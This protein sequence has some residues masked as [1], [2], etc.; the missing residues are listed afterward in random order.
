M[1]DNNK[2]DLVDASERIAD[3]Q[4]YPILTREIGYPSAPGQGTAGGGAGTAPLKG[5]VE[6]AIRD[7]LG[8]RPKTSDPKAF[9]ASLSQSF[10]S[11]EARGVTTWTWT[12]RTYAVQADMTAITGA[13]ASLYHRAKAALDQCI[14]LLDGLSTLD[15]CADAQDAEAT[16][17]IVRSALVGLVNELGTIGGPRVQ[18]V[19]DY[20]RILLDYS[21]NPAPEVEVPEAPTTTN[22][23]EC[24]NPIGCS[25]PKT[26][27]LTDP[28]QVDGQLGTLGDRFGLKSGNVNTIE[29]EQN[30]TNYFILVNYVDT[31][32]LSW[33]SDRT[34]FD[35]NPANTN[36]FLGTQQVLLLQSLAV[37]AESVQQA[38]FILDSLFVG[39]EERRMTFVNMG[40]GSYLSLA[41][42]LEWV[43][44]FSSEEGRLLIQDGGKDG[45]ISLLPTVVRLQQL[46]DR[47][48][49]QAR[50]PSNNPTHA[51]HSS[52]F[53]NALEELSVYLNKTA[54]LASQIQRPSTKPLTPPYFPK[55][56]RVDPNSWNA[57]QKDEQVTIWCSDL[58][59]KKGDG[60]Y[61]SPVVYLSG[62]EG[63]GRVPCKVTRIGPQGELILAPF[64]SKLPTVKT[65]QDQDW[66][67]CVENVFPDLR[68]ES[69]N[70]VKRHYVL[71]S[72]FTIEASGS[73]P[74]A[75]ILVRPQNTGSVRST[76]PASPP[77]PRIMKINHKRVPPGHTVEVDISGANFRTG[78]ET[79]LAKEGQDHIHGE[80]THVNPDGKTVSTRFKLPKDMT[81]G[82]EVSEWDVVVT[83]PDGTTDTL[84]ESFCVGM[85]FRLPDSSQPEGSNSS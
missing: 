65:D 6:N 71:P 76:P 52:R 59:V 28:E 19:D 46:V 51:F 84:P 56:Q 15:D 17:A 16:R 30:L 45:V 68:D 25:K 67:V 47:A 34:K 20:F 77:P 50:A 31:L 39:P 48:R 13:Q 61:I 70:P 85:Q 26:L 57:K 23:T 12:P 36:A 18:R 42:L 22:M 37:L 73:Q 11:D 40:Q 7:V 83:N 63:L 35:R 29:E 54:E 41:E 82:D 69:N 53:R 3:I 66:D 49:D 4:S 2:Q 79:K 33:D 44:Q 21:P 9:L 62:N 74:E 64:F 10:K 5:L 60:G 81:T 80:G 43:D 24:I 55:I 32:K 27:T 8:W 58:Y 75:G 1:T 38:Y 14:P 78:A 72:G